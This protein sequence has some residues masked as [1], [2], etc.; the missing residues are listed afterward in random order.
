MAKLGIGLKGRGRENIF[1]IDDVDEIVRLYDGEENP[2]GKSYT[3]EEFTQML[4]PHFWVEDTY[5]YFFPARA[6]PFKLP[7]FIHRMLDRYMGFMICA[8]VRKR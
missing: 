1:A 8:N 2:L 7:L 5:L 4:A 6:F 3:Y